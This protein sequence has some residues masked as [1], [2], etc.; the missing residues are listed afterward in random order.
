[1]KS[2]GLLGGEGS[3]QAVRPSERN[4]ATQLDPR[5]YL[6]GKSSYPAHSTV[7]GFER[8][9]DL[10]VA[11]QKANSARILDRDDIQ[12]PERHPLRCSC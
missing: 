11:L 10:L 2:M 12:L 1:M 7:D 5:S 9:V 4:M 3:L 6:M 8:R